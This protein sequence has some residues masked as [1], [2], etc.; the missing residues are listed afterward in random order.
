MHKNKL[1]I[2]EDE[3]LSDD[4]IFARRFD[5]MYDDAEKCCFC[6]CAIMPGEK[7]IQLYANGDVLHRQCW[8]EY[9]EEYT[10]AFGKEF[11]CN[12]REISDF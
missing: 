8:Q 4:G 6:G 2:T 7:A 10:E 9:A 11:T 12:D 5:T 3:I 1:E